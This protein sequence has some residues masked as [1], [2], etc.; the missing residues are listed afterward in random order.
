MRSLVLIFLACLWSASSFADFEQAIS[1]YRTDN[2]EAAFEGFMEAALEGDHIAQ[3]NVG[4]MYYRGQGVP[5]DVVLA[6]SWIDLA[7][8]GGDV[9]MVR[10]QSY[11]IV[12]LSTSQIRQGQ[13]MAAAR[14]REHGLAYHLSRESRPALAVVDR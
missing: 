4:V 10:A 8:E 12:E 1:N 11:L 14:A 9:E 6:Y 13:R 7:T 3:F 5:K 2:F